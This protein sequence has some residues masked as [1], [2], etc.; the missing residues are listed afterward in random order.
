MI[1]IVKGNIFQS[2]AE[3]LVNPVNCDGVMGAGLALQFKR[4]YPEMFLDYLRQDLEPGKLHCFQADRLIINFPT[5]VH[6][7]DLSRI[8]YIR[9]GLVALA[10][11]IGQRGIKSIAIP[12]LGCGLG[13]LKWTEVGPMIEQM[14]GELPVEI[15]IYAPEAAIGS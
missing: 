7:R 12:P 13:G 14:L 5:K 6:W 9:S 2:E 15:F 4:A 3:V 8:E 11:E 10:F 1:H